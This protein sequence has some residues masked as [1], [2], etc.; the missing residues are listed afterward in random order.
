MRAWSAG[1]K[2]TSNLELVSDL[3]KAERL[4]GGP[5][6]MLA[7]TGGLAQGPSNIFWTKV[8]TSSSVPRWIELLPI[9]FI[10]GLGTS[11]ARGM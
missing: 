5:K 9:L 4:A 1:T 8:S 7:W 10:G 11:R 2:A 3:K 6:I